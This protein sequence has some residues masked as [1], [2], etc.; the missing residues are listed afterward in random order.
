ME[1]NLWLTVTQTA[2]YLGMSK[3]S[4]YSMINDKQIRA[5][6]IRSQ[7]KIDGQFLS[8]YID[9]HATLHRRRMS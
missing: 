4:I 9:Q 1:K 5:V 2:K 7:W 8:D 3:L 6:K